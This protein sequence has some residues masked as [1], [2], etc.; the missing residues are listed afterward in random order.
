M[1]KSIKLDTCNFYDDRA[2]VNFLVYFEPKE[3]DIIFDKLQLKKYFYCVIK[4]NDKSKTIY[5]SNFY[6]S[7]VHGEAAYTL[8]VDSPPENLT[9]SLEV[10]IQEG[11]VGKNEFVI[12]EN[13]NPMV[14]NLDYRTTRKEQF[15]QQAASVFNVLN[16]NAS[17]TISVLDDLIKPVWQSVIDSSYPII[18]LRFSENQQDTY[19][20]KLLIKKYDYS[21]EEILGLFNFYSAMYTFM[22]SDNVFDVAAEKMFNIS[23]L[24]SSFFESYRE[25]EDFNLGACFEF[26]IKHEIDLTGFTSKK[27][28]D[29]SID[30]FLKFEELSERIEN[31]LCNIDYMRGIV[32]AIS[33]ERGFG[34]FTGMINFDVANKHL[35]RYNEF[36][37]N[38]KREF[39]YI[40]SLLNCKKN[41][42]ISYL[43]DGLV[44]GK[45]VFCKLNS[46]LDMLYLH[47]YNLQ[48]I[49]L[50]KSREHAYPITVSYEKGVA[51]N[52]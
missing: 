43:F 30:Y 50:E 37:L 12:L 27:Y 51:L 2:E 49:L 40:L 36:Y 3:I 15:L 13:G 48:E 33:N 38:S 34:E 26:D 1:L 29:L 19:A 42:N 21:I 10:F 46:S 7:N 23:D 25:V 31:I 52:A 6:Y 45:Q 39:V 17:S 20:S 18:E 8:F 16:Y 5:F 28:L 44:L 11:S 9:V 35:N 14:V 41:I 22:Y 32:S 4:F 24:N 47:V